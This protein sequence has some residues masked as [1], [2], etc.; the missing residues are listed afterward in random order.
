MKC[1]NC[2]QPIKKQIKIFYPILSKI[3]KTRSYPNKLKF[4]ETHQPK[5]LVNF[6]QK[7]SE[8]VL[9]KDIELNSAQYKKLKP[10][11]NQ[12][13]KLSDPKISIKQKLRNF[14]DKT[15]GFIGPLLTILAGILAN[16]VI[17]HLIRS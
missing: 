7:C 10:Y 6:L 17:P 4:F 1:V 8:A 12:L 16:T 13:L 5:C 11:K 14:K 3:A 9:R 2:K 15:G